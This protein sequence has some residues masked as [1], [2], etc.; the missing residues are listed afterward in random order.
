[1]I[2]AV[3]I[4]DEPN[5]SELISNL[6]QKFCKEV[7]ICGMAD[8]VQ[9]G[10]ACIEENKP[11]LVFLDIEMPDGTGFDLLSYFD[12]IDFKVIF[13]TA[14]SEFAIEAFKVAAVDYIL[15]PLSPPAL[16]SAV[17]KAS[18]VISKSDLNQKVKLLLNQVSAQNKDKK[19][20]LKTLER[21]YSVN[22]SEIIRFESEGSYTTV[23]F[24]EGKKIVVSKLIKEFDEMLSAQN[25]AR[26]HQSHLINMDYFFCYEKSDNH[27]IMKDNSEIPVSS[28]KKE[29]VLSLIN[30]I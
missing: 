24:Q 14:H 30:S 23:Y 25:F 21:I 12:T 11:D 3:I 10:Y 22:S 19:V 28:R 18:E 4:D 20:V 8:S 7:E 27:I 17:K 6:L 26:V 13:I 2:K 16:I 1:M 15:K 9:S 5:N 29:Y